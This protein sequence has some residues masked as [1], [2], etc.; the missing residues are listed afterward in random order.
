MS[1]LE[2][3]KAAQLK[4][5]E[6]WE[7][8]C[9]IVGKARERCSYF[10]TQAEK[11]QEAIDAEEAKT[12]AN[13][14]AWLLSCGNNGDQSDIKREL[15]EKRFPE[16]GAVLTT[17]GCYNA[18]ARQLELQIRMTR[19]KTEQIAEVLKEI[20]A[21]HKYLPKNKEGYV[22][23]DIFEETLS[24]FG[25][26]TLWVKGEKARIMVTTYGHT[27]SFLEGSL[28]AM[29]KHISTRLACRED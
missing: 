23:F 8:A 6:Q 29:I 12:R 17:S 27:E 14:I 9:D 19:D 21:I 5:L 20:R 2:E 16:Y 26:Y 28:E 3:L 11:L 22:V 1:T 4:A 25:I 18:D 15:L 24:R 13:D 7:E 10:Y